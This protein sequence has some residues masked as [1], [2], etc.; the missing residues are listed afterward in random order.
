MVNKI[1]N[2]NTVDVGSGSGETG[3]ESSPSRTTGFFAMLHRMR[4]IHRWS[5]M[6]NTE[7][8]N[9]M[10][11]SYEVAVIAHVLALIR[12]KYFAQNRIC[13]D[14]DRVAVLALYHD[15][16]EI[17]TGDLPTPVKYATREMRDSYRLVEQEAA[18]KLLNMLPDDLREYYRPLLF[19]DLDDEE[20]K[21]AM[22]LVKAADR[23]GAY[24]K[25]MDEL[26]AG[27]NEFRSAMS[28]VKER[29]ER[30]RL[31]EIEWFTKYM[32]PAY[33]KTLDELDS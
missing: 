29:L 22:L 30:M 1:N 18:Q 21:E 20:I 17:M 19:P 33:N 3:V 7:T 15:L 25:C 16:P 10:E 24:I 6:R 9:I 28:G 32:L 31:P 8:E 26:K 14:P 5:L 2:T 27:N 13:P 11:H 23:F 12:Q 4:Y